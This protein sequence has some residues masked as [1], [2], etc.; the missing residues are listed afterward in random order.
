VT[1]LFLGVIF[2]A[3]YFLKGRK[4]VIIYFSLLCATW[5]VRSAFSNE[6]LFIS[7]FPD[8]DWHAMIRIEYITLY[9][10]MIWAILFLNR[11]FPRE[12]NKIAKYILVTLNGAFVGITL[13]TQ[14]VFFTQF[15]T[16]YLATAG[17][18]LAYGMFIIARAFVNERLGAGFLAVCALLGLIIFGYDIFTYEGLFS[19]NSVLFNIG[20]IFIFVLIGLALLLHLRMINLPGLAA[21]TVTYND[22]FND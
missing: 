20:Y 15:L 22:L 11:L 4:K 17:L 18:L 2:F 13:V 21:D 16:L 7:F 19:Y 14:P 8:F 12:G 3:I 10:T 9:L 1:L 5:T 6:Y